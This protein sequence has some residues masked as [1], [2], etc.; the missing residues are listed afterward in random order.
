MSKVP[1]NFYLEKGKEFPAR[2]SDGRF[3][4]DYSPNCQRNLFYQKDMTS[5]QYRMYLTN[6][7]DTILEKEHDMDEEEFGCNDCSKNVFIP[8]N[9]YEQ[10]CDGVRC[11]VNF[12]NQNGHGIDTKYV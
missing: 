3:M 7:A 6:M 10:K 1:D 2:M 12:V 11:N 9:E 8:K 4:T 5:W